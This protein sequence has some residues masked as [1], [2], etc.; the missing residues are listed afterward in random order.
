[1]RRD[2]AYLF[3]VWYDEESIEKTWWSM[4]VVQMTDY[5]GLYYI[6]QCWELLLHPGVPR[7]QQCLEYSRLQLGP[8]SLLGYYSE[9]RAREMERTKSFWWS[10]FNLSCCYRILFLMFFVWNFQINYIPSSYSS[11]QGKSLFLSIFYF[12]THRFSNLF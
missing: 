9:F 2:F 11:A 6:L 4:S 10:S 7:F 12:S 3:T 5:P 1:M 8:I